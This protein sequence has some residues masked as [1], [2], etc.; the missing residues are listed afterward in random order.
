MLAGKI[1][2][3]DT[4]LRKLHYP[5]I[6]SPKVD[7]VRCIVHPELGPVSR[8]FK[9]LPNAS[10]RDRLM[11][12]DLIWLDGELVAGEPTAGDVFNKT[13]SAVMTKD[14]KPE[15]TYL[16]FD[17][18]GL[19]DLP[20]ASR[21]VM[22]G[23]S[24]RSY[25]DLRGLTVLMHESKE[26]GSPAEVEDYE[27]VCLAQGWEGIMLRDPA[28]RYKSGRSSL[29]EGILLK[30]KR[31]EDA[32]AI[33]TGFAP[34]ERNDNP[35]ELDA[36]GLSKRGHLKEFKITEDTLGSLIAESAQFGE[37]T[38]GSGFDA[39]Q[40]AHIWMH[41]AETFGKTVCFKY[42]KVGTSEKPRFPIFKGFRKD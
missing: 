2:D 21:F 17:H 32:E 31:M 30:L 33:V 14:G 39:A 22:A 23:N 16:V 9:P 20:Y 35:I 4:Q 8:S 11:Y 40:R 37:I 24:A 41:R 38:I 25:D 7:G 18:V 36:F 5:V 13:Q 26:L 12:E 15:L 27:E 10:T 34:L 42:Q 19:P 29:R 6:A 28:G 3:P 1:D